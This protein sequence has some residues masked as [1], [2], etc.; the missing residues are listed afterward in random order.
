MLLRVE[1]AS[2]AVSDAGRT[3]GALKSNYCSLEFVSQSRRRSRLSTARLTDKAVWIKRV[4][5]HLDSLTVVERL[6]SSVN[7]GKDFLSVSPSLIS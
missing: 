1:N 5:R 3:N 6:S 4:K 2:D 7:E